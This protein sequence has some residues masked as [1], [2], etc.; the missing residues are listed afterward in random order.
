MYSWAQYF[1]R[2]QC[3][4][5]L[6]NLFELLYSISKAYRLLMLCSSS[7]RFGRVEPHGT[8]AMYFCLCSAVVQRD[9]EELNHTELLLCT[10]AYAMQKFE[11]IR[12]RVEP[13]RTLAK[14]SLLNSRRDLK[15]W[16][17]TVQEFEE[18]RKS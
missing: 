17:Y 10:F 6:P 15:E 16:N 1:A 5:T 2:V 9:S 8:L 7:K 3:G 18:V 13:H 11:D 4:S 14:Y 12:K